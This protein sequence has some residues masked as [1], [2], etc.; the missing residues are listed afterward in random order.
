MSI[1]TIQTVFHGKIELSFSVQHCKQLL[2][3]LILLEGFINFT[4]FQFKPLP[5]NIVHHTRIN[6]SRE[7]IRQNEKAL[8]LVLISFLSLNRLHVKSA[9]EHINKGQSSSG[10]HYFY[11][12]FVG[13]I[14]LDFQMPQNPTIFYCFCRKIIP[15][16]TAPDHIIFG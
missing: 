13:N 9:P 6:S 8:I 10:P 16:T 15:Q 4:N 12:F 3:G 14:A 5:I 1:P 7:K 11:Y 2:S